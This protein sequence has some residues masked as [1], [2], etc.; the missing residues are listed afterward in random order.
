MRGSS[1][2]NHYLIKTSKRHTGDLYAVLKVVMPEHQDE[3][4]RDL[5]RQLADQADFDP[6]ADW[7][8]RA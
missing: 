6:R 1:W 4:S 7:E 3:R 2:G 5:W 8:K